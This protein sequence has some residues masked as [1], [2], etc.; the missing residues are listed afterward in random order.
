M[1]REQME[2]AVCKAAD[3]VNANGGLVGPQSWKVRADIK[4]AVQ[5]V[6][7][8]S[9][10][11]TDRQTLVRAFYQQW[12][13]VARAVALL[14]DASEDLD[15]YIVQILRLNVALAIATAHLTPRRGLRLRILEA[16]NGTSLG[17]SFACH[18][19]P[20]RKML[21]SSVVAG[22]RDVAVA[23][24]Q[25]VVFWSGLDVLCLE[26][27]EMWLTAL[28]RT[29][30]LL[31][32]DT[33]DRGMCEV[34]ALLQK[35]CRCTADCSAIVSVIV[36][37]MCD[38]LVDESVGWCMDNPEVWPALVNVLQWAYH[39]TTEKA[40][41]AVVA[42]VRR[43]G[44]PSW[45]AP[46]FWCVLKAAP[47]LRLMD[48]HAAS[49]APMDVC[50]MVCT[51]FASAAKQ[52]PAEA[53]PDSLLVVMDVVS[54]CLALTATVMVVGA[55]CSTRF[56]ESAARVLVDDG[57]PV[58]MAPK[59]VWS[60]CLCQFAALVVAVGETRSL[61]DQLEDPTVAR[62]VTTLV[63]RQYR[64]RDFSPEVSRAAVQALVPL[65]CHGL[66][67][68]DADLPIVTETVVVCMRWSPLRQWWCAAVFRGRLFLRSQ[69][70]QQ[71][72]DHA[73]AKKRRS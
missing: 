51:V 67:P 73:A 71:A 18:Q 5:C 52:E 8:H 45:A 4:K 41:A 7:L 11:W 66:A 57:T 55:V 1:A 35:A 60:L 2:A 54:R 23:V 25:A 16:V 56:L 14:D 43:G 39:E 46:R 38:L 34:L 61:H 28:V 27:L 20:L 68:I 40:T 10:N 42:M 6:Y 21:H 65:W 29:V 44:A 12:K 63:A 62:T 33:D 19:T 13:A 48:T 22:D 70:Q 53:P 47:L 26:E 31:K 30:H 36:P 32:D 59:N 17:S 3:A 15:R 9:A 58:H 49:V 69:Q 64:L 24:V 72:T 50:N 37:F